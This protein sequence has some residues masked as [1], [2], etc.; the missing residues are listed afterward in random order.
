MTEQEKQNIREAFDKMVMPYRFGPKGADITHVLSNAQKIYEEDYLRV[1]VSPPFR[2]M[3]DKAQVFPLESSDFIRTR[4]T[5][6]LEVS[7]FGYAIG[8]I[9]EEQLHVRNLI[10]EVAFKGH[11]ISNILK[12]A[13]LIH[14]IGNTPFGH[15][16]EQSFQ[17]FYKNVQTRGEGDAVRRAFLSMT[18]VERLDLLHFDGNVQGLRVV[19]KL[20]SANH[21]LSLDLTKAVIATIIKYPY[22][23]VNGNA[24]DSGNH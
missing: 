18:D 11:V 4:L 5:H 7:H 10:S 20:A 24:R 17:E 2:R 8:R 9:V 19:K 23:S 15:F 13:G 21:T 14:D 12:V 16:G 1:I 22:D 6:S 3:Q